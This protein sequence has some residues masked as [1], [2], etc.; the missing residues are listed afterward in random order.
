MASARR[1]VREQRSREVAAG[2]QNNLP[3]SGKAVQY[4]K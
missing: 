2:E 4:R 3:V 1:A